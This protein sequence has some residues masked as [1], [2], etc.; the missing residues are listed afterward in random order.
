MLCS[1]SNIGICNI[2]I[3]FFLFGAVCILIYN[4]QNTLDIF[5]KK[6]NRILDKQILDRQLLNILERKFLERKLNNKKQISISPKNLKHCYYQPS[7]N[8]LIEVSS[9]E[10]DES[11]SDIDLD[12]DDVDGECAYES[13]DDYTNINIDYIECGDKCEQLV[14]NVHMSLDLDKLDDINVKLLREVSENNGDLNFDVN[15]NLVELTVDEFVDN[16]KSVGETMETNETNET[17]ETNEMMVM[18]VNEEK[19]LNFKPKK[20]ENK[21]NKENYK[22]L[23]LSEL[24][25]YVIEHNLGIDASKM[26]K[27]EILKAIEL[28]ENE[29]KENNVELEVEENEF[30]E[31]EL[32]ENNVE[33]EVELK[34][35]NV[36]VEVELKEDEVIL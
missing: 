22:K 31:N 12:I 10:G 14:K 19:E 5:D 16:L 13:D 23:H 20:K 11:E 36:E 35:N 30:K 34:E 27:P 15:S 8:S 29:F 4:V 7:I 6:I 17:M 9:N 28:K 32:K 26:K 18:K 1:T 3:W 33:V 24:R 2:W 21:E 25:K